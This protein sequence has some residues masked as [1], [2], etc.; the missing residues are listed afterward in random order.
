MSTQAQ[1]DGEA[2]PAWPSDIRLIPI[3]T[4]PHS[5]SESNVQRRKIRDSCNNCSGQKIRCG[6]QRPSCARCA[7]KGLVC[8]YSFSQR[9]GRRSASSSNAQTVGLTN[10]PSSNNNT[11]SPSVTDS[12][13]LFGPTITMT[14]SL[15]PPIEDASTRAPAESPNDT[16]FGVFDDTSFFPDLSLDDLNPA[17]IET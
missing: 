9:T 13:S 6:K 16:Y 8:N 5:P 12:Q 2:I 14:P 15:S 3:M 17:T 10:L 7:T 1:Y 11:T 4:T